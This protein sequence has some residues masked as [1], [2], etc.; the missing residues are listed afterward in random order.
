MFVRSFVLEFRISLSVVRRKKG[1][2]G[3]RGRKLKARE[4]GK[5]DRGGGEKEEK[6]PA[7]QS[8]AM[9]WEE[10]REMLQSGTS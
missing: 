4:R 10:E 8:H 2:R 6:S 5:G 3:K 9:R 7:M 1:K